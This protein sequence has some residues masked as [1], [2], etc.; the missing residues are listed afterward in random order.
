MPPK[1]AYEQIQKQKMEENKK[2]FQVLEE[3]NKK[4]L[5]NK[6]VSDQT[7][8]QINDSLKTIYLA[9]R[10]KLADFGLLAPFFVNIS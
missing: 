9:N 1:K 7:K 3:S 5:S 8:E 4:F 2:A 6:E 10:K